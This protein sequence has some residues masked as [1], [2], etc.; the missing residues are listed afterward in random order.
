MDITSIE[1]AIEE[2]ENSP[3]TIENISELASL[4]IVRN[5]LFNTLQSFQQPDILPHYQAYV[6]NK[7]TYQLDENTEGAVI[8]SLKSLCI[9]LNEFFST[10][11]SNT[12]M[13][14]ERLCITELIETLH[15]KYNS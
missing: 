6:E 13:A 8:K 15:Q 5:N 11:Y 2:L 10:L 14:K 12:D 4:Y 9:D 7:R 3:T 1:G